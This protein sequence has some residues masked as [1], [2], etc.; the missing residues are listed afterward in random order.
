MEQVLRTLYDRRDQVHSCGDAMP[1]P[2]YSTV[3][4]QT[5]DTVWA[6]IRN[7]GNYTWAGVPGARLEN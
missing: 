4:D 7:F 1:K 6:S 2:Y 3:I 5:A